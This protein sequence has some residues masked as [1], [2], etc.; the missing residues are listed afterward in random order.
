[1]IHGMK[2]LDGEASGVHPGDYCVVCQ[3]AGGCGQG[4]RDRKDWKARE[5]MYSSGFG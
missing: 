4:A 3:D 5:T 1:M 2:Q